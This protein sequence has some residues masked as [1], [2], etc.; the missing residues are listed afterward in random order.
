MYEI[1]PLIP[2]STINSISMSVNKS[3]SICVIFKQAFHAKK[4]NLQ[5][6]F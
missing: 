3:N 6:K 1:L 5:M 2:F 4:W